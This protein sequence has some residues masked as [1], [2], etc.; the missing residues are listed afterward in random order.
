M[1]SDIGSDVPSSLLYAVVKDIEGDTGRDVSDWRSR[2]MFCVVFTS[3]PSL[4][5]G[6]RTIAG[7]CT[8]GSSV[9]TSFDIFLLGPE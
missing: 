9:M 7:L 5:V 2:A 3:S 1:E 6:D 8:T 4:E